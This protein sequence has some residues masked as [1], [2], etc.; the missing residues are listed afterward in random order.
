MQGISSFFPATLW[1]LTAALTVTVL[2]IF[3]FMGIYWRRRQSAF[4]QDGSEAADL[5]ARKQQAEADVKVLREWIDRQKDELL[6]MTAEREEQERIRIELTDLEQRC[7]AKDQENEALRREVG[8]LENQKL[9]A[10]QTL[11]QLKRDIGFIEDNRTEAKELKHE[12]EDMEKRLKEGREILSQL[13]ELELRLQALSREKIALDERI[14]KLQEDSSELQNVEK[15]ME[16]LKEGRKEKA[17]LTVLV[18]SLRSEQSALEKDIRRLEEETEE[19]ERNLEELKGD[20]AYEAK[21]AADNK[22]AADDARKLLNDAISRREDAEAVVRSLEARKAVLEDRIGELSGQGDDKAEP[23]NDLRYADLLKRGADCLRQDEFRQP[24][25]NE[26][27]YAALEQ[28]KEDLQQ[29]NLHFP[30]RIVDA[31]HTSLKCQSINPLTVLAGVS[32]TGKTLLPMK[33]A[34]LMGMH[35]LVLPVQPRWDSPQDL[36]GFYNYLEKEYKATELSRALVRMDP[37]NYSEGQ[38]QDGYIW[39]QKRLLMVLLDE[40]NLARTEYYFSEFLSKLELRRLVENLK[41]AAQREKAEVELDTGPGLKKSYRIWVPENVLFVGTMNEDETTQTLSDKVLDRSN[42]LRFGK[43]D[44]R[45]NGH[46][47]PEHDQHQ[48]QVLSF[49]QWKQWIRTPTTHSIWQEQTDSWISKIN[50]GLNMVGRPFGF[51]VED[52]IRLYIANYPRV[53]TEDRFKLAF[54][55]QVEQKIIPKLRGLDM[56]D[57]NSNTNECIN[58]IANIIDELGD[59]PLL[60]AF[61][62]AKSESNNMGMF[63]W[64]GVTRTLDQR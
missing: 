38:Q 31:F 33:Y 2:L 48:R 30:S 46:N 12:I 56:N 16:E 58:E 47:I 43:P 35:S 9:M 40:M 34:E 23:K 54:A 59:R 44:K 29:R 10:S 4:L 60:E 11:E 28:F 7:L 55:D 57:N 6:R 53:D 15:E 45:Q 27:E 22:Q 37:Y 24:P 52:A 17:Q 14:R 36:F 1:L 39:P 49:D 62:A 3:F 61:M 64:R 26:D 50:N 42:V 41:N 63:T 32:G 5:A 21:A 51:R 19:Q 18:G 20:V 8:E 13:P 25:R